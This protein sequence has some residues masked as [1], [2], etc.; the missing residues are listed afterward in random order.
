MNMRPSSPT[1]SVTIAIVA[2]GGRRGGLYRATY[3]GAV[4]VEQSHQP[5]LEAA[6]YFERHGIRGRLAIYREDTPTPCAFADIRS[7]AKI[8]IIE[9]AT[10]GPKFGGYQPFAPIA[11]NL[12][13]ASA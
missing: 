4:I 2:N 9:N 5:T 10:V 6:R 11:A 8:T 7:A 12:G 13:A 1:L 3:N